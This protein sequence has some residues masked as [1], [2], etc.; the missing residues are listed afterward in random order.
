MASNYPMKK[1]HFEQL[2][3]PL[4]SAN[5]LKP[6]SRKLLM[7]NVKPHREDDK[8]KNHKNSNNN[9]WENIE[10]PQFIDFLHLPTNGDSFF[11]KRLFFASTPLPTLQNKPPC[12]S[13]ENALIESFTKIHLSGIDHINENEKINKEYTVHHTNVNKERRNEEKCNVAK[14]LQHTT[15]KPFAFHLREQDKQKQKQERISKLLEEERKNRVFRANPLPRFLKPRPALS[16]ND[17]KINNNVENV[18]SNANKNTEKQN[19][20][21][22]QLKENVGVFKRRL[23]RPKTPPLLTSVR[24]VE[25]KHFDDA[26]REKERQKEEQRRMEMAAKKKQEEVELAQLRR[27]IV[28]KAQPIRKYKSSLPQIQKRPLT[29]PISP[30]L[31]KRRRTTAKSTI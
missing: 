31:L 11:D 25:R 15:V 7:K 17:N 14:K 6:P 24:A 18:G 2:N 23:I 30:R 9:I 10:S 3:T 27:Q 26:M 4:A 13:D 20:P 29:D 1:T 22:K 5:Y 19:T 28:H 21:K 16:D 8:K 12:S